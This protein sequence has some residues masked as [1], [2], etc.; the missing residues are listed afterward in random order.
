MYQKF[1]PE[2]KVRHR[3]GSIV[4][5]VTSYDMKKEY[6]EPLSMIG[7]DRKYKLVPTEIVNCRWFDK[8]ANTTKTDKFNQKDLIKVDD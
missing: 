6:T 8:E 4:M 5:T 7:G 1:Q 3:E 2:D